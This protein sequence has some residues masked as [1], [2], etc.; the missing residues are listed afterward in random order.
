[1]KSKVLVW[2]YNLGREICRRI[3]SN[4]AQGKWIRLLRIW[5]SYSFGYEEFCLLGYNVMQFIEGQ[6]TAP[7]SSG[8][9]I[10]PTK[11]PAW[12]KQHWSLFHAGSLLD[13]FFN[14]EDGVD[15]FFRNIGWFSTENMALYP[16][17]LTSLLWYTVAIS[18]AALRVVKN[19]HVKYRIN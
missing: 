9:K 3:W 5:G 13:L 6:L 16:S 7:Q 17:S 2:V 4:R 11:K 12:N 8:L 1:M 19:K 10:K 18:T 14:P 15:V